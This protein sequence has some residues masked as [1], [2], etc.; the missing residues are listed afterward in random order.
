M[1][2]PLMIFQKNAD[3][4]RNRVIIPKQFIEKWGKTFSME[5]YPDKIVLIPIKKGE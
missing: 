2:K 3:N 5:I 1:E 4:E